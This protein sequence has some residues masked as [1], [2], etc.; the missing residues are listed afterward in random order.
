MSALQTSVVPL[1][2][3][4]GALDPVS[5]AHMVARFFEVVGEPDYRLSLPTIGHYP[6]VEAPMEVIASY[7]AFLQNIAG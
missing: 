4:N 7:R 3:I 2:L 1:A 5:G 6:Q